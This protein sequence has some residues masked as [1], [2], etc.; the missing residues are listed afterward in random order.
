MI[1]KQPISLFK[2]NVS[3]DHRDHNN[4]FRVVVASGMDGNLESTNDCTRSAW[5]KIV[6]FGCSVASG[7]PLYN[8][9]CTSL[10]IVGNK[11][12]KEF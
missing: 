12:S 1:V 8:K 4:R 11:R 3:Y 9:E 2:S 6:V 5:V 7:S 10:W